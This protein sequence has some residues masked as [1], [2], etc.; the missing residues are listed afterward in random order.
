M[1]AKREKI[2][3]LMNK[4]AKM[5]RKVA[6]P[7]FNIRLNQRKKRI[8]EFFKEIGMAE[9][10]LDFIGGII[11]I[12]DRSQ[13][14]VFINKEGRKI[15]SCRNSGCVGKNWFNTFIPERI[16]PEVKK[17]F[18]QLM[19]GNQKFAEYYKN[20][21]LA[22]NGDEK[23]IAW[24]NSVLYNAKGKALG[25]LNMGIDI[26]KRERLDREL[27]KAERKIK[28]SEE[29]FSQVSASAKEWI[30][31]VDVRGLYT[32]TN[33]VVKKI[34][35]YEP[36]ELVGKKHFY[37]LFH[38]EDRNAL[39]EKAFE[40]FDKRVA[41]CELINRNV[42]KKGKL[43]W[44]ST[45]G[46][47]ILDAN[48]RL[49]GYRGADT[50][51]T[52]YKNAVDKLQKSERFLLNV[53]TS[54]QDGISVLDTELNIIQVNKTMEQWYSHAMP[55]I[56]K[57]CYEAYHG[58]ASP[59][60][61]C[62]TRETLKTKQA[63]YKVV[64]KTGSGGRI[65]GWLDLYAFPLL[66]TKTGE[67]KG[68]IEYVRD[69]TQ[70]KEAERKL[71]E[72]NK[73]LRNSNRKL[74]RLAL[75]DPQTGLYN[76]RYFEEI[77]EAE[78]YRARRYNSPLSLVMLDIDYFKSIND[79]YGHQFGDL[80]LRQFSRKLRR[81]VRLHDYVI[82]FG[83]EEFVIILPG[84]DKVAALNTAQ[85]LSDSIKMQNFGDAKNTVKLRLSGAVSSYPEDNVFK[86]MDLIGLAEQVLNK[87]KEY[88][89]DRV[90]SSIDIKNKTLS[91]EIIDKSTN[92]EYLRQKLSRLT[93]RSNQSLVESIFAFARTIELK[94]HYTGDHVEK[95][96][97]YATEIARKLGLSDDDITLIEQASMLHDLGKIGISEKILLKK[98]KLTKKEYE[99]IKEHPKIGVDIIRPIQFLRGL[100]P[101]I[102]YHHER[103]DG[104]G[105]PF[106]LKGR[107]IPVGARILALADVYQALISD[108]PYRKALPKVEAV[109]IIKQNSGKQF[110]PNIAALFLEIL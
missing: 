69:I 39:K 27:V 79:V 12:I 63:D 15:L 8:E 93:K 81:L 37:D 96:V 88:G 54:I 21:V 64:P 84:S 59:C 46:V 55:L 70:R 106:G 76:H 29:R 87:V 16:R 13:K 75:K 1:R 103:W 36:E 66:D 78:F 71:A 86:D 100:I 2:G 44:L 99:K 105:Y 90:C 22:K 110:D 47:P 95:T 83:G 68:V 73:D 28:N 85:R 48:G 107:E 3:Q 56:G 45:N 53:F 35:G 98:G 51:I 108:R 25:T 20:R 14:I 42:S 49:L 92:V 7:T 109:G 10:Y 77:I 19:D 102:L 26:T 52:D 97:N 61:I 91:S 31:E 101:L 33:P 74:L 30:W 60:K 17:C 38:P 65:D 43:V 67:L 5:H 80:V 9:Q 104:K 72:A 6:A 18:T 62:P 32:Y 34:L 23:V 11:V 58:S 50:D 94:D 40:V 41:F 4:L 82:R 57:K 89:G 24:H